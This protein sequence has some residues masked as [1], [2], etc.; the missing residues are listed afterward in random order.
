MTWEEIR[1]RKEDSIRESTGNPMS[2]SF[3][4]NGKI[5]NSYTEYSNSDEYKE[6]LEIEEEA[7]EQYKQKAKEYFDS[8]EID[9]K[10]LLFFHI[11]N[12]IFENYFKYNSSYRGLLYDKFGFGPEAYSLGMDSGMFALHNAISTPD[13]L[14]ERFDTLVKFLKLDL[15]KKELNSLRNIFLFGFDSTKSSDNI[16][17]GQQKFDFTKDPE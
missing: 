16:N 11:T 7:L 2:K 13:E 12:T 17:T 14:E 5:Y 10:L 15:S 6:F 1:Q 4:V 3:E 9:N 8:L